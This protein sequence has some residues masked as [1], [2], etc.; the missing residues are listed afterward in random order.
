MSAGLFYWDCLQL[1]KGKLE[2]LIGNRRRRSSVGRVFECPNF[3]FEPDFDRQTPHSKSG[4]NP[5][6]AVRRRPI[7]ND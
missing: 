2:D 5:D 4:Q 6:S 7:G 3:E 1:F